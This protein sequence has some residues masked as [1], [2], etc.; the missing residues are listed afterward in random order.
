M[1]VSKGK[2]EYAYVKLAKN[3]VVY[4]DDIKLEKLH[5][6]IIIDTDV[7][8]EFNAFDYEGKLGRKDKLITFLIGD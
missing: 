5:R 4:N 1:I 8:H 7:F 3:F 6:F 2:S